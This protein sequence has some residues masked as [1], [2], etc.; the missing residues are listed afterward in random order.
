MERKKLKIAVVLASF[1]VEY[2]Y[3]T[4]MGIMEEA[5]KQNAD[6]FL[7]NAHATANEKLQ[8]NKG[9]FNIYKLINYQ[10]F[11]G[12]ILFANLITDNQVCEDTI[13]TIKEMGVPTVSIDRE[14][15]GFYSVGTENYVPMKAI[16]DHLIEKHGYRKILYVSGP[17]YNSD[18]KERAMAYHDSMREHKLP[19]NNDMIFE[20]SFSNKFGREFAESFIDS[21][22]ELPDAVVC[23][24]D[25]IAIGL[26]TVFEK[27]GFKMPE[28]LH[29][30]GFDNNFEAANSIPRITTVARDM[31]QIGRG[32][33]S[34]LSDVIKGKSVVTNERFPGTP[35]YRES[36]G[37]QGEED[38][39]ITS[40]RVKYLEASEDYGRHIYDNNVT[41]EELTDCKTF[42]EFLE[43]LSHHLG[44]L[45]EG[46]FYMCLDRNFVHELNNIGMNQSDKVYDDYITDG[47]SD[48]MSVVL[49]YEYGEV[50]SVNDFNTADMLPELKDDHRYHTYV[51][52]P[53]HFR[54]RNMGY[55]IM[56]NCKF[57]YSSPMF[58]TWL[59]NLS[60][61]LESLRKQNHLKNMVD[62][63]DKMYVVD[64]L[65]GLYNRYGFERFSEKSFENCIKYQK[66]FMVLFADMDSLKQINDNLG[67]NSGDKAITTVSDALRE[68]CRGTE[69]CSRYGGDEF[70]VYAEKYTDED[71]KEYIERFNKVLAKMNSEIEKFD[72]SASIGYIIV[73]PK[74][75][76]HINQFVEM[77]DK[78]M[79]TEKLKK[80][81][82]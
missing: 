20:K 21:N 33:V 43:K 19:V 39:D 4:L 24:S 78:L 13:A 40:V 8:H 77:A 45:F 27:H 31:M 42:G 59:I 62:R 29:F 76:D 60:N 63:L 32:A 38:I 67:H 15:E 23:G 25:S 12:V 30:T 66:S 22:R 61:C 74:E 2:A 54:D 68:S 5:K 35:I 11:D 64:A 37:C 28:D 49:A 58:L 47:Y 56:D 3:D 80:K 69:I 70:V 52:S 10:K 14:I 50:V 34:K 71:A 46:R 75:G 9:E 53:L 26:R 18:A 82:V 16:V 1:N 17:Q 55:I 51:F 48:V 7:F 81:N 6:L 44:W 79:Y 73:T 36:C 57:P 41:V 65:T 72:A